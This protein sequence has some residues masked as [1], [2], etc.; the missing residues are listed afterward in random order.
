MENIDKGLTVPKLVLI[1]DSSAKNSP[2]ALKFIC[3]IFLSKPQ[4]FGI[5]MKKGFIGVRSPC[6]DATIYLF[7]LASRV[8]GKLA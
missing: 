7:V 5:S 8:S 2:N 6:T 4:K 1:A 3:P